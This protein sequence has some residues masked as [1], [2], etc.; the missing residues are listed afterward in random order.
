MNLQREISGIRAGNA[1]LGAAAP[2]ANAPLIA[3]ATAQKTLRDALIVAT[4]VAGAFHDGIEGS[5]R[6]T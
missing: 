1:Y 2:A 6:N 3:E 5:S 4:N